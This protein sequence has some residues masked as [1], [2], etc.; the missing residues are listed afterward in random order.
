V[1]P[2]DEVAVFLYNSAGQG[3]EVSFGGVTTSLSGPVTVSVSIPA[4]EAPGSYTVGFQLHDTGGLAA[5]YGTPGAQP[6]PGGPLALTI[7]S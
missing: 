1:A 5:S 4:G 2:V 3:G 7:T 6:V